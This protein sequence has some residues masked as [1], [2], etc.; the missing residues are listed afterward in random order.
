LGEL[1]MLEEGKDADS[2]FDWDSNRE[3]SGEA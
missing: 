2:R 3:D 1:A